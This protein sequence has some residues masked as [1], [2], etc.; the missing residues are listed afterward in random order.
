MRM[1]GANS[2]ETGAAMVP[3][4]TPE[5]AQQVMRSL[6][7]MKHI[8]VP[9]PDQTLVMKAETEFGPL[10]V[11]VEGSEPSMHPAEY[12][13]DLANYSVHKKQL[14]TANP[15]TLDVLNQL[16]PNLKGVATVSFS[17]PNPVAGKAYAAPEEGLKAGRSRAVF[18]AVKDTFQNQVVPTLLAANPPG[19]ALLLTSTPAYTEGTDPLRRGRIYQRLGMMGPIDPHE[20]QYSLISA[21]GKVH[22]L[23]I[24]GG[25]VNPWRP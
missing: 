18:N 7:G 13:S 10:D 25:P 6:A 8:R 11:R 19:S 22:P 16:G 2:L 1:A 5:H 21:G 9:G 4:T 12:I 3:V 24:F 23:E 20:N 14:L 17:W 15:Q